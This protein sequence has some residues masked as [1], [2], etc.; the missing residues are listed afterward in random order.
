[1]DEIEAKRLAEDRSSSAFGLRIDTHNGFLAVNQRVAMPVHCDTSISKED[2]VEIVSSDGEAFGVLTFTSV[3]SDEPL[4]RSEYALAAFLTEQSGREFSLARSLSFD[5]VV[6]YC[7]VLPRYLADYSHSSSIWGGFVHASMRSAHYQRQP[8]PQITAVS[9]IDF[10]LEASRDL[11]WRAV[12][13]AHPFERFLKHYHQ[14]ELLVDWYVA[15]KL[16]ALPGNLLGFDKLMSEYS[17]GDLVRLKKLMSV[18]CHGVQGIRLKLDFVRG[19]PEVAHG[20]FQEFDKAGNPVNSVDFTNFDASKLTPAMVLNL[21]AYWIFRV[22]CSVAHHKI[23]DYVL[24]D[25][26]QDFVVDFAEP[27]LLEVVR[28]VLSSDELKQLA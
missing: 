4:N 18:F 11:C 17:S 8:A 5:Y 12:Q 20:M 21:A 6:I 26:S 22:R 16:A 9:G 23:G 1:M 15:R 28:Q 7:A 19:F 14:L 13:A 25:S 24:R 10:P 27:L 3:P 2:D